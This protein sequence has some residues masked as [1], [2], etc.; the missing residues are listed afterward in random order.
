MAGDYPCNGYDLQSTIS[1]SELG[2]VQN[3]NDIWGWTDL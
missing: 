1:L 2:G 3:M